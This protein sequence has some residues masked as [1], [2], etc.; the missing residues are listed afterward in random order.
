MPH[1]NSWEQGAGRKSK[2]RFTLRRILATC[3]LTDVPQHV[4]Q[5]LAAFVDLLVAQRHRRQQSN[6]GLLR[7]VDQQPSIQ[8]LLH[9]RGPVDRQL[10]ADHQPAN[11]QL[12]HDRQ[13]VDQRSEPLAESLADLDGPIEQAFV[14][15][16]FDRG[17]ARPGGDRVAAE[18]GRVHAGPQAGGDFRR[19]QQSRACDAA[20]QALGQRHDIRHDAG[21]LIGKPLAR[22]AAAALHFIENQQQFVLVGQL[23]QA[24]QE[25]I[26]RN[27]DA[28]F[29]LDRLDQNRARLVVD[30]LLDGIQIAERR[31]RKTGQQR[32]RSLRDISAGP[33]RSSRRRFGRESRRGT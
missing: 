29:A 11:A 30:E 28:A 8:A 3:S 9:Q 20:A 2:P 6:H 23:P 24:F 12:L 26:R 33:S 7:A 1:G 15:N 18:R 32:A 5:N 13:F 31:V 16:R 4:R 14:F 22:A 17:N 25:T 27:A 10:Q 21:V 19:G